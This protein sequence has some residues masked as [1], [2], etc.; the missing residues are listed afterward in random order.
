[1]DPREKREH[2][3]S[4]TIVCWVL[5]QIN[6]ACLMLSS[7]SAS[8]RSRWL[9]GVYLRVWADGIRQDAHVLGPPVGGNEADAGILQRSLGLVFLTASLR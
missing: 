1:M 7:P 4:P 6:W 3:G 5:R 2:L 9:Q 8:R